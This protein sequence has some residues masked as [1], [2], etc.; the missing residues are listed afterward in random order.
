MRV[1]ALYDVHGNL[2]ALEAVLADARLGDAEAIVCGGDLVA[3]P[4]PADCLAALD[5]HRLSVHFVRGNGEREVVEDDG[6]AAAW[7][8][9]RLSAEQL[10]RVASWPLTA[11]LEVD[12]LGRVLFCH[13]APHDDAEIFTSLTPAAEVATL[14]A[15]LPATAVVGHTH[16]QFDRDAGARRVINAGSVGMPYEGVPGACWALLGPDVCFLRTGYDTEGALAA[17]VATGYP[18]AAD[19]FTPALRGEVS[20]AE[21][22]ARFEELRGT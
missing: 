16:V 5:A 18:P 17:L 22:S 2:P 1:A 19:W 11:E 3:G 21:A 12:A 6:A 9:A 10:G 7:C 20:P 13:A 15:G 4:M 14:F 8:R